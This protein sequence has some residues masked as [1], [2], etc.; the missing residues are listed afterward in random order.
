MKPIKNIETYNSGGNCYITAIILHDDRCIIISNEA[1]C[2]YEC[3][4]AFL[5][6]AGAQQTIYLGD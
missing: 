1:A 5:S 3:E 2:L 4:T 6:G